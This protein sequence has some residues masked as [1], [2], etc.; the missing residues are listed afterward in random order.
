MGRGCCYNKER[1]EEKKKEQ[2]TKKEE[3]GLFAPLLFAGANLRRGRA[4][5]QVMEAFADHVIRGPIRSQGMLKELV[6]D[7]EL[8]HVHFRGDDDDRL[9]RNLEPIG[10]FKRQRFGRNQHDPLSLVALFHSVLSGFERAL[11][12]IGVDARTAVESSSGLEG[13]AG[14]EIEACGFVGRAVDVSCRDHAMAIG[15][16]KVQE[17]RLSDPR[18]DTKLPDPLDRLEHRLF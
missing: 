5:G 2:K 6:N 9:A 17:R 3:I 13:S 8:Q 18:L 14:G 4:D 1:G 10:F 15:D 16:R 11:A 12:F 7:R